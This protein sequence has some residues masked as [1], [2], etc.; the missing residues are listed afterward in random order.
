MC[1]FLQLD[2]ER[3]SDGCGRIY[4]RQSSSS[5]CGAWRDVRLTFVLSLI[6]SLRPECLMGRRQQD[7]WAACYCSVIDSVWSACWPH[8]SLAPPTTNYN[9]PHQW[10]LKVT[11][12][13]ATTVNIKRFLSGCTV[14][15]SMKTW[16][17]SY[18]YYWSLFF[19]PL[20]FWLI[21]HMTL[22]LH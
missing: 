1:E 4:E 21:G 6:S 17:L 7:G 10:R 3:V 8:F 11:G 22:L 19:L 20:Y 14:T 18:V 13:S 16:I 5:R 2:A 9:Q 12:K 15:T